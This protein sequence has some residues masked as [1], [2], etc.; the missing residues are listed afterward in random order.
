MKFTFD[1]FVH[2]GRCHSNRRDDDMP[3]M[4]TFYGFPVV[5]E[6]EH[7]VITA[8]D[9]DVELH[10]GGVVIVDDEGGITVYH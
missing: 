2:Y 10:R 4:F 3:D 6:G 9:G 8:L 7:F 5:H 1:Q